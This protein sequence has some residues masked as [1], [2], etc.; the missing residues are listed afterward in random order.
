[1]NFRKQS[2]TIDLWNCRTG[3]QM[4]FFITEPN[5]GDYLIELHKK[6]HKTTEQVT[7]D[8]RKRVEV[9]IPAFT[10]DYG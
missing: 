7:D 3:T 8:I 2:P 9:F 6:R 4:G 1:M 5:R 10:A